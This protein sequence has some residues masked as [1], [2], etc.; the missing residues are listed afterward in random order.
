M[1]ILLDNNLYWKNLWCPGE[2]QDT[3]YPV[4]VTNP[5]SLDLP[6]TDV[7]NIC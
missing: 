3:I 5:G 7:S 1:L 6:P 4:M 2:N